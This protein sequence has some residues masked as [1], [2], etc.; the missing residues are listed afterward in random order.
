MRFVWLSLSIACAQ[1]APEAPRPVAAKVEPSAQ[2]ASVPSLAEAS[3]DPI[4]AS[5]PPDASP[6]LDA[7]CTGGP[8]VTVRFDVDMERASGVGRIT[9]GAKRVR[10][11]A[12]PQPFFCHEG[13]LT[14]SDAGAD[15]MTVSCLGDD[16]GT[17]MTASRRGDTLQ[18]DGQDY[19]QLDRTHETVPLAKC[20][21][22]RF[23]LGHIAKGA[24][25]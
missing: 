10:M 14:P 16:R 2:D 19:S 5:P 7:T 8:V 9:I 11:F 17:W 23:V 21:S 22:L 24:P 18:L 20:A 6:P 12:V 4:D 13:T 15:T 25:G 1:P 3:A